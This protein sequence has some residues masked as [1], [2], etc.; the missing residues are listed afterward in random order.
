MWGA[1][2]TNL[3]KTAN[4]IYAL[5]LHSLRGLLFSRKAVITVLVLLFVTAVMAY[6][7]GQ[8]VDALAEGANMMDV[9]ILFFFMPVMAMIFG[10]S[11]IRDEIDNKSI[12]HVATAPLDRSFAYIGYYLPLSLAVSGSMVIIT[13]AGFLSF[14]LQH[15][16]SG[17][18]LEMYFEFI[19]LVVLGSIVYSS[20]FLAAS[21]LFTKPVFFGLFYAFIWEGFIGS[22]PGAI[23]KASIKHYLRSMGSEW[24]D[25]GSIS[26][27]DASS[28]GG[29]VAVIVGLT[30][31]CLVLGAYLLREKELS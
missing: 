20:L 17:D 30:L 8:D 22:I 10:S 26:T 19:A 27:F 1:D 28:F 14:F 18:A 13:T 21:V 24:V 4:G 23:Q 15:D 6:A 5:T 11:L 3:K 29:S 7:G 31:S 12:T 9:L 16:V 25:H 2:L